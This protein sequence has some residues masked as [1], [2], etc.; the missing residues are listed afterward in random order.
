MEGL[1]RVSKIVR[2]MNQFAYA[3]GAEM[4]SVELNEAIKNTLVMCNNEIKYVA[5]VETTF[6]ELPPVTCF[7]GEI[8]QVVLNLVVNAAHAIG[9][10]VKGTDRRGK[11]AI[12]TRADTDSVVISIADTGGGIPAHIRD[13]IFDPFFTTKD[14]GRG[15]GQGLAIARAVAQ[16]HRGA[17][18]F[19]TA[20][21]I[22]TT[23]HLRL[24]LHAPESGR[25]NPTYVS[26]SSNVAT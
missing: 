17:L 16:K 8:N 19:D 15:T 7:V 24:P 13:R 23:F 11:I 20:E 25:P 4:A 3:D 14:V 2:S 12:S 1:A 18:E 26:R 5:D 22:G 6:G 10:R 9:D 21:G